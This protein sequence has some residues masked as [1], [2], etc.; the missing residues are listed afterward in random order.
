MAS[1]LRIAA[2]AVLFLL[3]APSHAQSSHGMGNLSCAQFLKAARS[4]DLLYHQASSWLLGYASG[5][6]EVLKGSG[7]AAPVVSLSN[8]Q[9]LKLA[10]DY[11]EANPA[12]TIAQ[13]AN[14]WYAGLPSQAADPRPADASE[15]SWSLTF[16]R[17]KTPFERR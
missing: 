3:P 11:C 4:S 8:D 16:G 6:N 2:I 5:R 12:G 7:S 15:S 13:A 1:S 9:L 17:N 10:G 14:E